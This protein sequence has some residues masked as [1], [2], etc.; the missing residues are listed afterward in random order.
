MGSAIQFTDANFEKEVLQSEVPVLV[1]FSAAWCGPCKTLSPVIDELAKEYAGVVKVGTVD[2]DE[3]GELA[4]T[5]SI[6]SVP[7]VL[8]FKGGKKVDSVLGAQPKNVFKTKIE[9]LK[10]K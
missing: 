1:D 3:S 8:F 9:S 7:T 10:G 2:I 4:G 6:M 5:Y